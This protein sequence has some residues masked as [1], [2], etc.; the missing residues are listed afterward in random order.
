[1]TS[2]SPAWRATSAVL[3]A[4]RMRE[5]CLAGARLVSDRQSER[6]RLDNHAKELPHIW[7]HFVSH[8]AMAVIGS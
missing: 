6:I 4:S 5:V 2:R 1:V 7:L 8:A 3:V